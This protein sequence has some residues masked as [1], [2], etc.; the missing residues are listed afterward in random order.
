MDKITNEAWIRPTCNGGDC[1]KFYAG[2]PY[3]IV[4]NGKEF[5]IQEKKTTFWREREYW[6]DLLD[7]YWSPART[8]LYETLEEAQEA[9]KKEETHHARIFGEWK[10][11]Q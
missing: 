8:N 7:H 11:V 3:R 1:C 2:S 5:K 4:T 9:L 6:A 10:P